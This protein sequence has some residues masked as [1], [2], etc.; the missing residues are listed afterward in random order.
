M[1]TLVEDNLK[2]YFSIATTPWCREGCYSFPWIAPL[3]L[4]P[5]PYMLSLKQGCI[6]YH[7]LSLW[8]DMT[9]SH[10]PLEKHMNK[11]LSHIHIAKFNVELIIVLFIIQRNLIYLNF[12]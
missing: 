4:D 3:T 7:F 9:Q 8:Y 2:A 5:L 1:A 11:M 6:K 12:L 10:R